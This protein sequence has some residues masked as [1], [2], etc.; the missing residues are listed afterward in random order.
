LTL[1]GRILRP[2]GLRGELRVLP[3]NPSLEKK[4]VGTVLTLKRREE[5]LS[6]ILE[7]IR[8][9]GKF[10]LIKLKGV[11][12][13]EEAEELRGFEI[14]GEGEEGQSLAGRKVFSKGKL[15]GEIGEI[16]EIP[17]N[18]VAVVKTP[19]GKEVLVPLNLCEDRGDWLE[20][21]LPEGLEE[22]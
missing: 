15:M 4:G 3:I 21:N 13:V 2:H 10:L 8:R 22:L 12:S 19:S 11:D 18:P 1:L 6:F 14:Y 16:L 7:G 5:E 17:A 20:A 9:S